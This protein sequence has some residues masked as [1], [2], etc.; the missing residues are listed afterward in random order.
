MDVT[1]L[2][3]YG[4]PRFWGG[5]LKWADIVGLPALLEDITAWAR[6]DPQ[7]WRPAP[8]LK[9]LVAQGRTFEDLNKEAA[10]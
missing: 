4:F 3:G 6:E 1:L 2:Y 9:E 5:P 7:V 10:G 8:L